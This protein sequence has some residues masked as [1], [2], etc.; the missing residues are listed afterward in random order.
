LRDALAGVEDERRET[1]GLARVV[2]C[3]AAAAEL[4]LHT[5]VAPARITRVRIGREKYRPTG[6]MR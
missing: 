5:P 1:L 4:V 6:P 3:S 2:F